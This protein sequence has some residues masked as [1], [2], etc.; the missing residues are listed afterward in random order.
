MTCRVHGQRL[1]VT[2]Q[3]IILPNSNEIS[4]GAFQSAGS[5]TLY[6]AGEAGSEAFYLPRPCARPKSGVPPPKIRCRQRISARL[7]PR[8]RWRAA[9]RTFRG[10]GVPVLEF[11]EVGVAR[12]YQLPLRGRIAA[13]GGLPIAAWARGASRRPERL[14]ERAV[15]RGA[16][17]GAAACLAA[18]MVAR[19]RR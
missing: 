11:V 13:R 9:V 12:R 19:M 15:A 6:S 8:S 3:R 10:V 7:T 1:G 5:S 2:E 18:M 16:A 4:S 14:V 17:G